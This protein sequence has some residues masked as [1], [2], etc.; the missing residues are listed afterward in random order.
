M[1][2]AKKQSSKQKKTPNQQRRPKA[3]KTIAATT[4]ATTT[5]ETPAAKTATTTTTSSSSP[6]TMTETETARPEVDMP[7]AVEGAGVR[8]RRS[9]TDYDKLSEI[10]HV[11][12]RSDM[13]V[14]TT[15]PALTESLVYDDATGRVVEKQVMSSEALRQIFKEIL[16]NAAD[17]ILNTRHLGEGTAGRADLAR[18]RG[19]VPLRVTVTKTTIQIDNGGEPIPVAP[20]GSSTST[21]I[22]L[23]PTLVFG[24][25]RTSSNMSSDARRVGAGRNGI[26]A[27]AANIFS[28]RFVVS[29]DDP[30][31]GQQYRGVWHNHMTLTSEEATPGFIH[32]GK[33]WVA[34][35]ARKKPYSGAPR[36]SVEY[37][38]D[39]S[40]FAPLTE[41][42]PDLIALFKRI[43]F[44]CS[45]TTK[46]R[47]E[48]NGEV[49]D[50][51][52][53]TAFA[54]AYYA[55]PGGDVRT[56]V[57]Y[58]WA[59][60]ADYDAAS[61]YGRGRDA[62]ANAIASGAIANMP[63]VEL[64][65]VDAANTG[66]LG[67]VNGL[68]VSMGVH[69]NA[70]VRAVSAAV[71]DALPSGARGTGAVAVSASDV[72]GYLA[73]IANCHLPNPTF[74]SQTKTVLTGPTPPVS[75]PSLLF[76]TAVSG[77]AE[78]RW[79]V[80][81]AVADVAAFR[82]SRLVATT[83][84]KRGTSRVLLEKGRDAN[85]AGPRRNGNTTLFIC[86]GDS[87]ATTIEQ[88]VRLTGGNDTNGV[89]PLRGKGLNVSSASAE[90][91]SRNVEIRVIKK[92]V[93]LVAD[94]DYSNPKTAQAFLRYDRI[95]FA[96]DQ[97]IDGKHI[98]ALLA[99][100][101]AQWPS[102][103]TTGRVGYLAT[104]LIRVTDRRSGAPVA[105][106][107]SEHRFTEWL[108]RQ[109]RGEVPQSLVV[110][111][112]KG[113]A[114]SSTEMIREDLG[115]SPIIWL[116]YDDAGAAAL[117]L[118]F[119]R[120]RVAERKEWIVANVSRE[121]DD[122]AA[123]R[124]APVDAETAAAAASSS[125][126]TTSKKTSSS[127]DN[128]TAMTVVP[129]GSRR[130]SDMLSVDLGEYWLNTLERA[131]PRIDSFNHA[132]RQA[133]FHALTHFHY[134][135]STDRAPVKVS[136]I[137]AA[138]AESL[139]Y[140]HGEVSLANTYVGL[141]Q[142]FCGSNNNIP[143]LAAV[144]QFGT[145]MQNGKDA[146]AP[147]YIRT[148]LGKLAPLLF[149]PDSVG[150]IPQREV[151]GVKVEPLWVPSTLPLVVINGARGIATG[152]STIIPPH[153][154]IEVVDWVLAR[155]RRLGG[156]GGGGSGGSGSSSS[157]VVV[158]SPPP[159]PPPSPW[160]MRFRGRVY[161]TAAAAA[162]GE[163]EEEL[164][165]EDA[166]D[167]P[168]GDDGGARMCGGGIGGSGGGGGGRVVVEGIFDIIRNATASD[169]TF[170]VV[171]S[172]I[173]VYVSILAY[174]QFLL[175][176]VVAGI[177]ADF[178]D[179]STTDTASFKLRRLNT[180]LLG[181]RKALKAAA[182]AYRTAV[183]EAASS[184]QSS[185]SSSST[186]PSKHHQAAAAAA[187]AMP[188]L[189]DIPRPTIA[190]LRLR[191]TVPLGNM[192]IIDDSGRPRRY[193]SVSDILEE[194]TERMLSHFEAFKASRVRSITA[195]HSSLTTRHR[196]LHAIVTKQI[197]ITAD[198]AVVNTA[199]D[200]L[201]LPRDVY[202]ELRIRDATADRVESLASQ[203]ARVAMELEKTRETPH[204]VFWERKLVAV[205][206]AL[207]SHI[208]AS[209]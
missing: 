137:A 9:V 141:A 206:A 175:S 170:D 176:L 21:R 163:F 104:P 50:A 134:S 158:S 153:H 49:L 42:T 123:G 178:T 174:R 187:A 22:N 164:L 78:S 1:A 150:L 100:F 105:R 148:H 159:P 183:K 23:L 57:W 81:R 169:P 200:S 58:D 96:A 173:P 107:F 28:S 68:E 33:E 91:Q 191:K 67:F 199:L 12:Q 155:I 188:P 125:S 166:D 203:I 56:L 154:P 13:Y 142:D 48:F 207:V 84:A 127:S 76:K 204:W 116:T 74:G 93:G 14:G 99:N 202:S 39:F 184:S 106:F 52:A 59:K 182:V 122:A 132:R 119:D 82:A 65:V 171:I 3:G 121:A 64:I 37:D 168:D 136:H 128:N 95:V 34:V 94:A 15:R 20:H 4:T 140:A 189:A 145:R 172:E 86:E 149:D 126:T 35:K 101:F 143:I 112:L 157:S 201:K 115:T 24:E 90:T 29:I 19:V 83:D 198:D 10:E 118:S 32:D 144:G 162:P 156:G 92:L 135:T 180:V 110:S 25:L 103:F 129:T 139:N 61:G 36:V 80:V 181:D 133:V 186:K 89:F 179:D 55:P 6:P 30:I 46:I 190:S 146:G 2:A 102:L 193:E 185:S 98:R 161:T 124:R 205:R 5:S 87:A 195:S 177:L 8:V 167:D 138:A 47:V 44:D 75:V 60:R 109:P 79:G 41:Y 194:Y 27:K 40:R 73:V 97:D 147:R 120:K 111:Y 131:I 197:D 72:R 18:T 70:A 196:L 43:V 69:I 7:E 38:I 45:F 113:L 53:P 54:R 160:F 26:G 71:L 192:N 17:N 51:R 151:E 11:L 62:I 165:D 130:L 117:A 88:R 208:A 16:A 31:R 77:P 114:S 108:A 63:A 209:S 85:L 66:N 152:F